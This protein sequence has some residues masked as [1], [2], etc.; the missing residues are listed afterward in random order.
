MEQA[1]VTE[2]MLLADVRPSFAIPIL[3]SAPRANTRYIQSVD[4]LGRLAALDP[5][6]PPSER[7][8]SVEGPHVE[9]A[10]GGEQIHAIVTPDDRIVVGDRAVVATE[11]AGWVEEVKHPL[12]RLALSDFAGLDK[13]AREAAG[14]AYARLRRR[15]SQGAAT[16]WY[17]DAVLA[18]RVTRAVLRNAGPLANPSAVERLLSHIRLTA[19]RG[20]L[21]VELPA[22]LTA[23]HGLSFDPAASRYRGLLSLGAPL[24][25]D[26]LV[27]ETISVGRGAATRRRAITGEIDVEGCALVVVGNVRLHGRLMHAASKTDRGADRGEPIGSDEYTVGVRSDGVLVGH[28]GRSRDLAMGL[29][30]LLSGRT[31]MGAILLVVDAAGDAG[32]RA[33]DVAEIRMALEAWR[34]RA[35]ALTGTPVDV[36]LLHPEIRR[37]QRKQDLAL[38]ETLPV[39]AVLSL[40]NAWTPLWWGAVGRLDALAQCIDGWVGAQNQGLLDRLGIRPGPTGVPILTA[41]RLSGRSDRAIERVGTALANP[42]WPDVGAG[43][44]V[45]GIPAEALPKGL[46]QMGEHWG[47]SATGPLRYKKIRGM[48]RTYADR[49]LADALVAVSIIYPDD[50]VNEPLEFESYVADRLRELGWRV[51]APFRSLR[52]DYAIKRNGLPEVTVEVKLRAAEAKGRPVRGR[53]EA[54]RAVI[55]GESGSGLFPDRPVQA[56]SFENLSHLERLVGE[57]LRQKGMWIDASDLQ[58]GL[59]AAGEAFSGARLAGEWMLTAQDAQAWRIEGEDPGLFLP[60]LSGRDIVRFPE[61]RC[62]IDVQQAPYIVSRGLEELIQTRRADQAG[63]P[64][65]FVLPS[66]IR[67]LHERPSYL[68]TAA[69]SRHRIF[70]RARGRIVPTAGVLIIPDTWPWLLGLLSSSVHRQ[71]SEAVG[72]QRSGAVRYTVRTI[73]AFPMPPHLRDGANTAMAAELGFLGEELTRR[74][75]AWQYEDLRDNDQ[76]ILTPELLNALAWRLP[77]DVREDLARGRSLARLYDAAPDWL[78]DLQA[79]IDAITFEAYGLPYDADRQTVIERLLDVVNGDYSYSPI[80]A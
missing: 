68:L 47:R 34:R 48:E 39:R 2:V 4:Y 30:A 78:L 46:S 25:L 12:T 18:P 44:L 69:D 11:I 76:G 27:F 62:L 73:T 43:E 57:E 61:G 72:L 22:E 55:V 26:H 35:G 33:D 32:A 40:A 52:A 5:C 42:L 15:E 53:S 19:E 9:A 13:V 3:Q 23:D 59:I 21:H 38:A 37:T 17:L 65:R 14:A 36:A 56:I 64:R 8:R 7:L 51:N 70:L 71:W 10:V 31:A 67:H 60:V 80:M 58:G 77:K 28:V 54:W 49:V 6:E 63:P 29:E 20:S 66:R 1:L 50:D 45:V 79:R 74:R 41:I 24:Q 16:R 75:A